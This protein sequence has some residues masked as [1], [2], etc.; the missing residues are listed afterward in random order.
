MKKEEKS[1]R[2]Y[3]RILVATAVVSCAFS[4]LVGMQ[5][6]SSLMTVKT[7]SP[8]NMPELDRLRAV[9]KENPADEALKNKVRDLDVV[10]RR[11]Y[12]TGVLSLRT[13][14]LLVLG[15]IVILL[16]SLKTMA[17]LRR[18]LPNPLEYPVAPDTARA[19]AT[20]RWVTGGVWV[21]LFTVA[22]TVGVLERAS[23]IS[24]VSPANLPGTTAIVPA[25]AAPD[26]AEI[27]KNWPG[28]RGP[29][30]AGV[31]VFTNVPIA[32]D[33]KSGEGVLWK[34]KV[35][36][37]GM[38]SPVIWG[39]RVFLTG[40][41]E[42]KREVYCYDIATGTMLWK[43]D[44]DAAPG[45]IN[46][47][48]KVSKDTGYAAPTP[49]VDGVNIYAI[50]ANGDIAAIDFCSQKKW[51]VALGLPDNKYGYSASP[52]IHKGRVLVQYDGGAKSE[53]IALSAAN[54][55]KVWS[56]ARPVTESWPSPIVAET[57]K[58]PQVVTVANE[59]IIAYDPE[60]GRELW[61]VKCRGSEVAPTPV[62]SRGLVLASVTADQIYAI[63]PDGQGDVSK[64]NVVWKSEDGV[65]DVPSPVSNGELVYFASS[66]GTVTCFEVGTGKIMW[67]K[68]LDA[69]FYASPS[70]AGDRLYLVARS[71]VVFVLRAGGKYEEIAKLTLGEPSDCLPAFADG[72][73]IMRG[74]TTLFCFGGKATGAKGM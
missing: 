6:A 52:V 67:D 15:G 38:S 21:A 71:G 29:S 70:L 8:L 62:F 47:V 56:T 23:S 16:I 50:F 33:V 59:W 10:S 51:A 44:V 61:R 9:V 30:S 40:A 57:A 53:L 48:P 12:F 20:A 45:K 46:R 41:S 55:K 65:S 66:A 54:G 26:A 13:G 34:V 36:L 68:S 69:E 28:F 7:W 39:N 37:P 73:I 5:M 27:A 32:W 3:Y 24:G 18:R 43:M 72:R 11:F 63:R 14:S 60:N 1:V 49:V 17:T 2:L 58:G 19:A 74:I 4:I 35:P 25:V 31:S 22:V 42:E 64:T